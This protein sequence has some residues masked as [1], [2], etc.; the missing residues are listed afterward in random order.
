MKISKFFKI[1][2]YKINKYEKIVSN[3]FLQTRIPITLV[4]VEDDTRNNDENK[5][6]T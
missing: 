2:N 3:P 5:R 1:L 6:E 4:W